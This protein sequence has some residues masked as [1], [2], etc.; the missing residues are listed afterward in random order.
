MELP[1]LTS[2]AWSNNCELSIEARATQET[3]E[4]LRQFDIVL[5]REEITR[6]HKIIAYK[7]RPYKEW[8]QS[9]V[10]SNEEKDSIKK[11][12]QRV[13]EDIVG[14]LTLVPAEYWA[15]ELGV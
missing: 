7:I 4:R 5:T 15:E 11:C 6:V 10:L 1:T 2:L 14:T 13:I 12:I 3:I 9:P 8:L